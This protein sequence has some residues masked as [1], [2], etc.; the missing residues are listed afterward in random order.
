MTDIINKL[1]SVILCFCMLIFAPM[2]FMTLNRSVTMNRSILNEMANFVDKICDNGVLTKDDM[3]DL[4]LAVNSFGVP[5]DVT[6]SRYV[7]MVNPTQDSKG[8]YAVYTASEVIDQD[9][10]ETK[11]YQFDKGDI[12]QL[13]V[14]ALN[15]TSSQQIMYNILKISEKKFSQVLA[16]RV[17]K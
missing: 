15:Y 12:L 13:E 7:R 1:I 6:L 4:Y 9:K 16:G 14:R 17:R 10:L 11:D 5:M 8:T 3:S 2:V